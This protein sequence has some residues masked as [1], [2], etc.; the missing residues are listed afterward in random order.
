MDHRKVP[1][2]RSEGRKAEGLHRE[3]G[4]GL[5]F[6]KFGPGADGDY[7]I[8]RLQHLG[9]QPLP[10]GLISP[11][12]PD[13]HNLVFISETG[14]PRTVAHQPRGFLDLGPNGGEPPHGDAGSAG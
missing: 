6:I 12:D 11:L 7:L 8:T 5:H 4:I 13:Y 3:V 9:R 1:F 14:A 10:E 2:Y